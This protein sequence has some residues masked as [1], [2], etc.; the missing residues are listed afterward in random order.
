MAE[1]ATLF[2]AWWQ[3]GKA[4]IPSCQAMFNYSG[5]QL[6]QTGHTLSEYLV[7][8]EMVQTASP[9]DSPEKGESV[10]D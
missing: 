9:T 6:Q 10:Q 8:M 4:A 3:L 7:G 2:S 1:Q 5:K